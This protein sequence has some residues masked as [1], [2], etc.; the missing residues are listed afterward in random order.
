M[1]VILATGSPF[2]F[3][4]NAAVQESYRVFDQNIRFT[5]STTLRRD[6]KANARC[7]TD[8]IKSELTKHKG[9]VAIALDAWSSKSR[10]A[11][12][13]VKAYWITADWHL[14]EEVIGFEPLYGRHSGINLAEV[15]N[16]LVHSYGIQDRLVSVT[17][18]NASNNK[19]MHR[20]LLEM[21]TKNAEDAL[22]V[23][24]SHHLP[25]QLAETDL[26]AD[27]TSDHEEDGNSTPTRQVSPCGANQPLLIPCLAHVLQLALKEI[28]GS[29]NCAATNNDIVRDYEERATDKK[30]RG[31]KQDSLPMALWKVSSFSGRFLVGRLPTL[32]S[33]SAEQL[34]C[35]STTATKGLK[36][37]TPY[38][39]NT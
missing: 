1:R 34:L 14:R 9:R 22:Y 7:V 33:S 35:G 28:L 27:P 6:V 11:F 13:G 5:S 16:S 38:R 23:P 32:K 17:A 30:R 29:L 10:Q 37:S 31:L 26:Y 2:T 18:D 36:N 24:T 3:F 15:V 8:A 21:L 39:P 25:D 4:E 20:D 12:L 19:A